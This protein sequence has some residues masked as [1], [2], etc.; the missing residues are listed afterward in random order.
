M[1]EM[2]YEAFLQSKK[3]TTP[4]SG[5]TDLCNPA[6]DERAMFP[7]QRAVVEWAVRRGRACIFADT[8]LGK[9]RMQLA[10]AEQV[11]LF[12]GNRVLILA[13]LCVAQQTVA[14]GASIGINVKYVREFQANGDTGIYITNYEMLEHFEEA[15]SNGYFD[16]IV[17]DEASILKSFRGATR[18]QI[19]AAAS[20]LPYRLACT[21][22]PAPNDFM[23][24]GNQA[25]FVGAMTSTRMLSTFFTHDGS[26]TDDHT[27]KW[28]LKGHAR[29]LFWEWM[30]Q[31]AVF[32]K[33]PSDIGYEDHGYDLPPIQYVDHKVHSDFKF[34]GF[35]LPQVAATIQ[36][37]G[38]A[39]RETIEERVE[40]T[41]A[42]VNASDAPF[43]VWCHLNGESE[44]LVKAIPNSVEVTGSMPLDLKEKNILKFTSGE[45]RVIVTKPSIAGF[46]MNWQHCHNMV[47]V[48]LNDSFEQ[49][50]QAVRRC[51]RFG[52][53]KEV[54][55]HIIS[56]NLD[57]AVV[58][59]IQRKQLQAETIT[60]EMAGYM[61][62]FQTEKF[63]AGT[64]RKETYQTEIRRGQN[65]EMRLGDCCALIKELPDQSVDYSIY[66]IPFAQLYSYSNSE[67]DMSNARSIEE[68][69]AHYE[70]LTKDLLKKMR[71]GRNVSIHLMQLR[72][73]KSVDGYIGLKDFRGDIIR[74][75]QRAGFVY[76]SEVCIWKDP[77]VEMQRTKALGLLYKQLRADGSM[78]RQ[79]LADYVC[80]FRAPGQN[81]KPVT[82]ESS[83]IPLPLWQRLASP[84]WMDIE[85]G[86][87]LNRVE[88]R[89][90]E[91]ERHICPLQLPV[92]E[93]CLHLWSNPGDLVLS[94]FAGIGSEGYQA[95]KMK[96]RFIGFELK[97]QYY[98]IG[99][100]NLREAETASEQADLFASG[101]PGGI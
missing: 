77:V 71:P 31:W 18:N 59:N 5:F 53:T 74:A 84:V 89:E 95:I 58:A 100:D 80:T 88:A 101:E 10:W 38:Q 67:R 2:T 17:I 87:T 30:S 82:H 13:P 3:I 43:I 9:T 79:G 73:L 47:F 45:V 35:L 91:D 23:E 36:E 40:K 28:R 92:I 69:Y 26:V 4:P 48:G 7:F 76:Q 42:I 83:D 62:E 99:C 81:E 93:R 1:G 14:E 54:N 16:G 94:P 22:T 55:V 56:T 96:R 34:D 29:E 66:S 61:R 68:F 85:Q 70:F 60:K 63:K 19:I 46:G 15:I 65:W 44:S 39:K 78:S 97:R 8:G 37:R 33:K 12:T 25:E 41:A 27:H 6:L 86:K 49:F 50:Y 64:D 98:E 51:Y 75:M 11:H 20:K 21:A 24:L 32:I 90:N 52:Q 57:V 72:T